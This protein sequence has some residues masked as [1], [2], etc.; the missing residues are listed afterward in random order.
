M[1]MS[2]R[3]KATISRVLVTATLKFF[4]PSVSPVRSLPTIASS[5]INLKILWPTPERV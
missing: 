5:D 2:L 4:V 1:S 3:G